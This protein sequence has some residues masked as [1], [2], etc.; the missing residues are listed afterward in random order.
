MSG[1]LLLLLL[2]PVQRPAKHA[3]HYTYKNTPTTAKCC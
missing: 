2:L 3:P 1:L